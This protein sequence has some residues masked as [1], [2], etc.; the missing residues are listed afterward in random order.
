MNITK[1]LRDSLVWAKLDKEFTQVVVA[2]G[3][4]VGP[5]A[6][7]TMHWDFLVATPEHDKPLR[8]YHRW[9]KNVYAGALTLPL[10][11]QTGEVLY[12]KADLRRQFMD[13]IDR[14]VTH[15]ESLRN[16]PV[17]E[18]VV[19]SL[20]NSMSG[21]SASASGNLHRWVVNPG[22]G[23]VWVAVEQEA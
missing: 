20:S 10:N 19:I 12:D 15:R 22:G 4:R 11:P 3:I 16:P 2:R 7:R 14:F 21:V 23:G 13:Q 9:N 8:V 1:I 6:G 17:I 5:R 18:N